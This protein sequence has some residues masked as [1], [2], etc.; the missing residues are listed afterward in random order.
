[1]AAWFGELVEAWVRQSRLGWFDQM[2]TSKR[3]SVLCQGVIERYTVI[4]RCRNEY[5]IRLMCR[6]LKVS[7]SGYSEML[8]Y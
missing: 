3:G 6:C 2:L 7:A 5:P 8:L 4:Q 1:M